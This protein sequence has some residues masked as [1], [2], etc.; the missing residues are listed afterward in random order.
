MTKEEAEEFA[1]R[2]VA[3]WNARDVEAVL[4]HFDDS[5]VFRSPKAKLIAGKSVVRGKEELRAYW[6]AASTRI[7]SLRF[8]LDHV[9]WDGPSEEL[10]IVYVSTLNG[11]RTRA[12]ER[13]KLR[14]H[15][16]IEGEATYG[17]SES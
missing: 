7:T 15:V 8:E 6:N 11:E 13:L 9:V 14:G 5:V 16:V 4:A 2:W 1:K 3:N 10:V 17:V 12:S